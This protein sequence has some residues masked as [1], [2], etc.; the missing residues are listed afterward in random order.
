MKVL[1]SGGCKN[2]KSTYAEKIALALREAGTICYYIATMK[3]MDEED[4]Q[5]ISRHQESRKNLGFETVEQQVDVADLLDRCDNKGAF[6]LDSITALLANEMFSFNGE[7]YVTDSAAP[8]R[9]IADLHQLMDGVDH[10]VMVSDYMYGD[11]AFYDDATEVYRQ[12]LAQVDQ[13]CAANC[14]VVIEVCY[15]RLIVYKGQDLMEELYEKI[16]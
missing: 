13:A 12:G 16:S 15:G 14:D 5:R 8:E 1:I 11:T 4:D 9:V 10:I 7:T 2:G 6:L 3:P